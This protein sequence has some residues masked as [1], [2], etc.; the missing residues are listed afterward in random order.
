MTPE[1]VLAAADDPNAGVKE[2][3]VCEALLYRG[4]LALQKAARDDA[5]R[6]FHSAADEC[7]KESFEVWLATA[8]LRALGIG[9]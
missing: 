5:A 1:T 9:R 6:L 3:Q 7:P 8:E 4:E 2:S